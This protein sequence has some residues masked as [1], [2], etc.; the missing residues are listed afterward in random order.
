MEEVSKADKIRPQRIS[1]SNIDIIEK[2]GKPKTGEPFNKVLT[3]VLM[4]LEDTLKELKLTKE[5]N[6]KLKEELKKEKEP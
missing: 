5:E 6:K 1:Q 3:R 4:K 2:H